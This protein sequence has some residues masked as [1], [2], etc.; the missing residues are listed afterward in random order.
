MVLGKNRSTEQDDT[1]FGLFEMPAAFVR[2]VV[3]ACRLFNTAVD[4]I[5][6]DVPVLR[7]ELFERDAA[8]REQGEKLP[9]RVID[10]NAIADPEGSLLLFDAQTAPYVHQFHD[11]EAYLS[12]PHPETRDVAIATITGV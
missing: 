10:F 7:A 3:A 2:P 6:Y 11:V 5:F 8:M 1:M 9:S 12:S 4:E